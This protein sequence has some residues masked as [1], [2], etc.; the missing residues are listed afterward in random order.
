MMRWRRGLP[1]SISLLLFIIFNLD[2][3]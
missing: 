1:S 2:D 3:L